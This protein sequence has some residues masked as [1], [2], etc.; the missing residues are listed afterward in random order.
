VA[1]EQRIK[2]TQ[3]KEKS[4]RDIVAPAFEIL[5]PEFLPRA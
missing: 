5:T 1:T 2:A 4:R 3:R